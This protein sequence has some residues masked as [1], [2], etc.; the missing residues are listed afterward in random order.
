MEVLLERLA[1]ILDEPAVAP[2]D[3]LQGYANWDSLAVLSIVA[4]AQEDYGVVLQAPDIQGAGT[5]RG[6][7]ALIEGH[8]AGR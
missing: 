5:A 1:T 7:F 4:M 3:A 2:D 6:L 8:R